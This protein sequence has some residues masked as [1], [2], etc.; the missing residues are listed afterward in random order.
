MANLI[1]AGI[2]PLT[3][4][5][6]ADYDKVSFGDV[7]SL[8]DI[9]GRLSRG[10]AVVLHNETTGC[11]IPLQAN[12]TRRQVEMLLAGGLLDYTREQQKKA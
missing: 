4:A 8:P 6:E 9:R 3:F 1:N 10:E 11:D 2:L 12:F 7:L 5:D